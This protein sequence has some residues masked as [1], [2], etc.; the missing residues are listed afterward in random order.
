MGLRGLHTQLRDIQRYLKEVSEG[1][2]PANHSVTYYIQEVL[3]LLP[4]VTQPE[5]VEAHNV[6]TNDQLMCIYLGSL[7]R[8]IIALHNLI[9]NKLALQKSEKDREE[10]AEKKKT[11]EK[12]PS[13]PV[14]TDEKSG[15][16]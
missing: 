4:D 2:L 14:K 9:D 7:I 5:F 1:K 12:A 3:N 16:K 8:T 11:A 13:T 6:Q 15:K 10:E